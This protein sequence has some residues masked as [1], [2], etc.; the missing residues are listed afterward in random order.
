MTIQ[1]ITCRACGGAV[2]HRA[3][4]PLPRCLF[5]DSEALVP[6]EVPQIESPEVWIPFEL[7]ESDAVE[8]FQRW[9]RDSFWAPSDL[10]NASV[11]LHQLMLPAWAWDGQMEAH[12]AALVPAMT[13]SG[14]RPVSGVDSA[15]FSGVLVPSS[16]ALSRSE[17]AALSPFRMGTAQ[18]LAEAPAELSFEIGGL[19]RKGARA[20]A[21]NQMRQLHSQAIQRAVNAVRINLSTLAHE[22]SGKPL[23]LPIYIGAFRRKDKIYRV[24]INGQTGSRTGTMPVSWV[25]IALAVFVFCACLALVAVWLGI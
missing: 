23:L 2:A 25:K 4:E 17:L 16:T 18:N 6:K 13:R 1:A 12:W 9:V 10:K 21:L 7:T 22:M 19:S 5:C 20:D 15:E 8:V 11:E 14:K 24:V 3:G